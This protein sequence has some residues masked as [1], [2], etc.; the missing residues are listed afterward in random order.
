MQLYSE[1]NLAGH[2]S[3]ARSNAFMN[4][5]STHLRIPNY[6]QLISNASRMRKSFS[7]LKI[8]KNR[9]RSNIGQEKLEALVLTHMEKQIYGQ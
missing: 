3:A 9:L 1:T 2:V 6:M 4:M 5:V 8:I 7:T